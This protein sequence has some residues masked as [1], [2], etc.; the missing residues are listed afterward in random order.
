V[1]FSCHVLFLSVALKSGY[2]TTRAS[3][4]YLHQ[5]NAGIIG[6]RSFAWVCNYNSAAIAFRSAEFVYHCSFERFN[7]KWHVG[8]RNNSIIESVLNESYVIILGWGCTNPFKE[9]QAFVLGL[10][11]KLNRKQLFKT[12]MH[13][14]RGRYD[15]FIQPFRI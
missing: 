10:L 11:E 8:S 3:W 5:F 12:K 9:R 14:A 6:R 4:F 13:P 7:F 15:G 2:P 1:F